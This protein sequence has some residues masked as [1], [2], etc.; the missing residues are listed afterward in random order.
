MATKEAIGIMYSAASDARSLAEALGGRLDLRAPSWV[1]SASDEEGLKACMAQT[2]VV[3]SVGGDGTILRAA[4][5]AA[6][7]EVP[8]LGINLGRLGFMTELRADE[9]LLGVSRYLRGEDVWVEERAML[10]ATLLPASSRGKRQAFHALNDVVLARG[11]LPRL[12]HI[13]AELN[14]TP[15]TTYFADAVIVATATG[16]TG[17]ALAAGGPILHA[18]SQDIVVVPVAPHVSLGTALVLPPDTVITLAVKTDVP[19]VVSVDGLHEVAVTPGDIVQVQGSPYTARFLR[20][21]D[22]KHFYATLIQRLGLIPG[23]RNAQLSYE[24]GGR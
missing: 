2:R 7:H 22:P 10:E 19:V 23:A 20:T 13:A 17:Y 12:V 15:L 24:P 4:R 8:V 5:A 11:G 14:G 3:I 6:P 1:R 21:R 16:S 18:A 9:A